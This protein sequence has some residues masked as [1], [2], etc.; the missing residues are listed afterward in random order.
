[1]ILF[2][3]RRAAS[4]VVA[5]LLAAAVQVA[6]AQPL[7]AGRE[8]SAAS[9]ASFN[10]SQQMPVDPEDVVGALPNGLRFYVRPNPRPARQAEL[11][12]VV[13]AGSVLEDDDQR[14]LAHFV[15]HM[16]FEGTR[17]FPGQG[18]NSFL[19]SLGLS[20]GADANAATGFDET[21]YTLRVPTDVPGALD[22]ALTVLEDWAGGATFD[23]SG[24]ER[25]RPIVLAEWRMNLGADERTGEKV[26]HVQLEG[27]RYAD[28]GPIGSPDVI[29]H[30]QREQ[31]LRFY[32][33]W[34]RPD[35]MAVI[36]V[37][38]VD[39]NEVAALIRQHFMPLT[40]PEPERPRPNFDVPEHPDTRY[41]VVTDKE[42]TATAVQISN[43]RPAR[44]QGSVGG[45]RDIMLDQLFAAMLGARLDEL[46]QSG[47]PPFLD[48][49]ADRGLFPAPRTRDQAIV[50]ALVSN[51]GVTRG[52]DALVTELQR[53]ARFGFTATEL[54]RAKQGNMAASER[55]VTESPDRESSS[56]ADEFTR[57]FLE[58]EAL[59][60]IWQELAFHR[61]F[62]PGIT[63]S[64]VNALA[65]DWFPERNRLV[66]VSAPQAAGVVLPDE[67]QLAG[68]VRN[69]SEKGLTPY[70]DAG[71][72]HTLMSAPPPRGS[73]VKTTLRPEAGITEWTLSNGATVVLKPTTLKADQIL[74]RAAAPGG[75]SLASDDD[76]IAARVA[77]DVIAAGGAGRFSAVALDKI[78]TGRALGVRPFI[79][80]FDEGMRGGSTPQDLETMFQLLYLRFTQPRADPTAFAAMRS[81]AQ[82]LLANQLA[83]PDVVFN[84][85]VQA[86][87]S[88]DNPRRQPETP[89]TVERWNLDKALAFYK[90]RFSDAGNFTFVFVGS[91]TPESIRPLV[92]T[93]VASLPATR[94][95]ETWRDLGI[96]PPRGVIERTIEKGIAPKS[97]VAIVFTGSLEYDDA[98][99]LAFETMVLVLQSRLSDAIREELGG[100]YSITATPETRRIPRPEYQVRIDWTCD[101]ARAAS[102]VQRVMQEIAFV[103]QTL[104]PPS[105]VARVRDVLL[106]DF[107]RN[108]QDNRY[109]LG[110]ISRRYEEGNAANVGAVVQLPQRI[111]ELSGYAIQLAAQKYL[112]AGNYVQITLVPEMK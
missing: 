57:N 1:M 105:Q 86:A 59:P 40:N 37:G 94:A 81:Q 16:Q 22:R 31:L 102:L 27:S 90:A 96:A 4:L 48:A 61:R 29:Q 100:T 21:Q 9:V 93:Y 62:L 70:V 54:D 26:R 84:R 30:A 101:P 49:A 18:I 7:A 41:T 35:L 45:Y 75:I 17:H 68:A 3:L 25:Q 36:V 73:I 104:L 55:V 56:R 46:S 10:L 83:S 51:D 108:S 103:R 11:R 5:C 74:F 19:G 14:G 98:D 82:A 64:E 91:F 38:D 28:R 23:P 77:D 97:E 107:D 24:I 53:V 79:D 63:L 76:V 6:S 69:A 95:H 89:A 8:T 78:L 20:I 71:A 50:Q 42:T 32:T 15:E 87:L 88:G 39:R 80:E 44:N 85:A 99:K 72:G 109:L 43:L 106:R 58:G 66:V 34:Y 92:E 47:N 60:T 2:T 65:G 33:D 111:S 67:T 12:L 52:L 13:K 112:D 110:Q